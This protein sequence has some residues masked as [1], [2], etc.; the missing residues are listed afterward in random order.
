MFLDPGLD[1]SQ[2][3]LPDASIGREIVLVAHIQ[4]ERQDVHQLIAQPSPHRRIERRSLQSKHRAELRGDPAQSAAG[5]HGPYQRNPILRE[6][7]R[8]FLARDFQVERA[9]LADA[10]QIVGFGRREDRSHAGIREQALARLQNVDFAVLDELDVVAVLVELRDMS[11]APRYPLLGK[12][13]VRH[14]DGTKSRFA[15]EALI[16]GSLLGLDV[17]MNVDVADGPLPGGVTP[18]W[19]NAVGREHQIQFC[20]PTSNGRGHVCCAAQTALGGKHS[21]WQ[22]RARNRLPSLRAEA[23]R[24]RSGASGHPSAGVSA[25]KKL[26][27]SSLAKTGGCVNVRCR[28]GNAGR[29]RVQAGGQRR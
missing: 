28:P 10:F 23:N 2:A 19:F 29:R 26:A 17:D 22:V 20:A 27:K 9:H 18:G 4:R 13:H 16:V 12:Q 15:D 5:C 25:I 21:R 7:F 1:R 8:E 3:D 6:S 11:L 24:L 14:R